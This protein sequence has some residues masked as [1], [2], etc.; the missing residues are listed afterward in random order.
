MG[1]KALDRRE[2]LRIALA[3]SALL[4]VSGCGSF[5][6]SDSSLD[7]AYLNLQETLD[8]IA[9]DDI[10][11]DRLFSIARQI[12]KRC[13]ELT[14]EHDEI[15]QQ[16]DALSRKRDTTSFELTELMEGFATRSTVERD[17]LLR[18]QDELRAELTEQEWTVAVEAL[19]Q[20]REAYTRPQIGGS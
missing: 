9:T 3:T 14:R 16:F 17:E 15:H 10:R 19:D 7:K 6:K 12:E 18:M 11:Q 2:A 5:R 1:T 13:Q 4:L 20:T 8:D